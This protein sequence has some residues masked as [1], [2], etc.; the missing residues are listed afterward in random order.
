MK[1][2]IL[3]ALILVAVFVFAT[4]AFAADTN[5]T[6]S[7]D[8]RTIDFADQQPIVENERVLVPLRG[9]FEAMGATV[10]W[11]QEQQ[12]VTVFS[13]DNVNRLV[14]TL[15]STEFTRLTFKSLFSVE[16]ES[17]TSEVAPVAVNGRT[18]V[19]IYLIAD[20]MYN[21]VEW[22][23][24]S[25]HVKFTSKNFLALINST[26][27][28]ED[29]LNACLPKVSISSDAKDIKVGDTVSVKVDISNMSMHSAMNYFGAFLTVYYDDTSFKY[30]SYKLYKD[31]EELEVETVA[32]N[33]YYHNDSV[34]FTYL[35]PPKL[36]SAPTDGTVLE[37][38]FTV[39]D[40][41]GGAFKLSDRYTSLGYDTAVILST[42]E[43]VHM[44]EK[45]NQVYI[46]TTPLVI[47]K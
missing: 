39:T 42:K 3:G 16:S 25:R 14:L 43:D 36:T 47:G 34:K 1:K 32:D 45:A 37:L 26:E 13:P 24:E 22:I 9:V 8:R 21:D 41:K 4:T 27:G 30:D 29:V 33:G 31:G 17:F 46:D 19:P 2:S 10:H 11:N 35:L 44:L 7:V 12:K 40:E 23:Q 15:G 20:Y 18:M 38:F 5:V 28:G 6:V